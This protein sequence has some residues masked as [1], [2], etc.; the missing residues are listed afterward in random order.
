MISD[1]MKDL[2]SAQ[3]VL[4]GMNRNVKSLILQHLVNLQTEQVTK[5]TQHTDPHQLYRAQGA[6]KAYQSVVEL[7]DS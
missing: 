3:E 7:F 2:K 5:L 6:V 4:K 1:E